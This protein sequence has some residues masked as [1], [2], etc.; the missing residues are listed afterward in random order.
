MGHT[1][2]EWLELL[3]ALAVGFGCLFVIGAVYGAITRSFHKGGRVAGWRRA[4]GWV[5][6]IVALAVILRVVVGYLEPGTTQIHR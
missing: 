1:A 5:W 6:V 3:M 4:L 2:P